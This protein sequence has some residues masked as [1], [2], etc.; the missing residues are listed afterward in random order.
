ME[1]SVTTNQPTTTQAVA[2]P[3]PSPRQQKS[4]I[5]TIAAKF[6]VDPDRLMHTLKDTAFKQPYSNGKPGP[7]VTNEQMVALL[8]VANEYNLN[9]FLKQ[10]YAF[11]AKGGGVV[12]MVPI[13]GW[14]RIIN[15]HPQFAGMDLNY[16]PEGTAKDDYWVECVIE[17]KDRTKPT[18]IRE[19]FSECY[20]NTDPWNSHPR[21]MTRHKAISQ[22]ARVAFN[23]T[24]IYDPDE[25][26]RIANAMAIDAA[27]TPST[28]PPTQAPRARQLAQEPEQTPP[29]SQ[30]S[31][32]TSADGKATAEQLEQI[33]YLLDQTGI[34]E[35]ETAEQ[36]GVEILEDLPFS[37]VAEVEAW[38]R[39]VGKVG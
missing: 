2:T 11:P 16:P 23:F 1:R 39:R 30:P 28:K 32:E 8:V 5:R 7:E 35:N 13:D 24:G 10:I 33:R 19:Y 27:V 14:L 25:G 29:T 36:F 15:E 22:C 20:R 38:I 34:P 18:I 12:P 37:Q 3:T 6:N 26:E 17:R 21:R 31:V 4:L 9:P